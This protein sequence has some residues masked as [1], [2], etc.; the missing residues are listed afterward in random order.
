[1]IQR[2][3]AIQILKEHWETDELTFVAKFE[4]PKKHRGSK[5]KNAFGFFTK[6]YFNKK[7]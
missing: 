6:I 5:D 2:E 3:E 1:M 7:K 4:V